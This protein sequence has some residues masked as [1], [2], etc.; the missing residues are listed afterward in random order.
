MT[1]QL[2]LWEEAHWTVKTVHYQDQ[3]DIEDTDLTHY[4]SVAKP[5]MRTCRAIIAQQ[6]YKA[7]LLQHGDPFTD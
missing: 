3:L 2:P 4:R 1:R 7:Y 6:N 5:H